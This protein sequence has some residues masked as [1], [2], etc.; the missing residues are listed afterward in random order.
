VRDVV[1]PL[2]QSLRKKVNLVMYSLPG[3]EDAVRRK[4]YRSFR[5]PT[6]AELRKQGRD[7]LAAKLK[8]FDYTGK[9]LPKQITLSGKRPATADYFAQFPGLDA[10]PKYN[11]AGFWDLPIPVMKDID[12]GLND[13][14]IYDAEGYAALKAFLKSQGV[15]HVLLCG[16]NTDMCVCKTTAGY[17]NLRNDFNVFLIGD[18]TLATFPANSTPAAATNA[19][20]SFASLNLLITQVSWIGK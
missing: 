5:S 4:M 10:G 6:T 13:V 17:E 3:K 19:A 2:V 18:A 12:V 1:N 14:V 8:A 20:V 11:N 16:Y 9:P 15:R 7:E